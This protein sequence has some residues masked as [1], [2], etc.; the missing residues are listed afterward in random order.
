MK[1][2]DLSFIHPPRDRETESS[3][4]CSMIA[5]RTLVRFLFE[6]ARGPNES[7]PLEGCYSAEGPAA[8]GVNV[9]L[10]VNR[11]LCRGWTVPG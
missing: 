8:H 7:P 9:T 5:G 10:L 11:M 3:M 4:L 2:C 1:E 6:V